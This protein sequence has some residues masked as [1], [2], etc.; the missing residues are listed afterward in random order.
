MQA[1]CKNNVQKYCL[2][3][4]SET[5][6]MIPSILSKC[7]ALLEVIKGTTFGLF[8]VSKFGTA[9]LRRTRTFAVLFG[10]S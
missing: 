6:L 2:I 5:F 1:L 9:I 8:H 7:Q 10:V 3:F 4:T